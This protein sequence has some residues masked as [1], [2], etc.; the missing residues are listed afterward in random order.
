MNKR[1]IAAALAAVLIVCCFALTACHKKEQS[2]AP[3]ESAQRYDSL[4]EIKNEL[5]FDITVPE[6]I[7][8][9]AYTIRK[10]TTI[11][12]VYDGGYIRKANTMEPVAKKP[13]DTK[14]ETVV[15]G[16]NEVTLCT[17]DDKVMLAIWSDSRNSYCLGSQLGMDKDTAITYISQI[18]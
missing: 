18:K 1:I 7:N 15:V 13:K 14:A 12:V 11:Q 9:E 3:T 5:G 17:K 6:D 2:K 4:D 8:V 10:K 16:E